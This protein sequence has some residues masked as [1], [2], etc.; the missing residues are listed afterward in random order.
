MGAGTG[1]GTFRGCSPPSGGIRRPSTWV[2]VGMVVPLVVMIYYT[3]IESW[4]AAFSWFSLTKDYWGNTSQEGMTAYLHSFQGIATPGVA[5]Q[6][7]WWMPYAFFTGTLLINI[8]VLSKGIAGG[9][10]RLAKIGMPILFFFAVVLAIVV[11][12]LPAQVGIGATAAQGYQFIYNPDLSHLGNPEVWLAAGGADLLHP[13]GGDGLTPGLR[14]L[15]LHKG[16]HR[17]ERH[18]HRRHQRDGGGGAGRLHRHSRRRGVL[19]GGWG[20]GHRTGRGPSIWVSPPCLSSSRGSTRWYPWGTSWG[21]CGSGFSSSPASPPPWPCSHPSWP[22]S[23]KSSAL[24]GETV[25]WSLGGVC[26]LFGL[27]H[28]AWLGH[29]FLDEWDYWAGTFGL[30]LVAILETI[31]FVWIF[32]PGNA[33]ASIHQ[34][35]DIRIP[36]VFKFVMT[37]VTPLYLLVI[38]GWWGAT[39]AVPILLNLRSAGSELPVAPEDMAYVNL[40]RAIILLFAVVFLVLVRVAWRRNGYDSRRGFQEISTDTLPKELA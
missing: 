25:A 3:Y 15:P 28:I 17:F 23:G 39:E 24:G 16:R 18:R 11:A 36:G 1:R 13:L 37:Y 33:W 19:R 5:P 30:V 26:F 6:H 29:G 12:T 40:S 27:M 2:W 34:G 8:W 4:T 14:Q 21:S 7:Q 35:A 31:V 10:E 20:H 22:F 38:L 9:I 32:R